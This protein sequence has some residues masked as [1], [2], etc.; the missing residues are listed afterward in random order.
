MLI[1]AKVEANLLYIR[2]DELRPEFQNRL[3]MFSKTTYPLFIII[4]LK[5]PPLGSEPMIKDLKK[6]RKDKA[7]K[8][9][10]NW[11]KI[12]FA[13]NQQL[14]VKVVDGPINLSNPYLDFT[15]ISKLSV[16][17]SDQENDPIIPLVKKAFETENLNLQYFS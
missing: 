16:Y 9:I 3:C 5:M 12:C 13:G 4:Q 15:G 10:N 14:I 11:I 8:K 6:I 2:E 1:F 17:R 7:I